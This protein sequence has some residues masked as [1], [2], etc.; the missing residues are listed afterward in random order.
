MKEHREIYINGQ[1][2][3]SRSPGLIEVINATSEAVIAR[4]PEGV[5]ED[6]DAVVGE[7][8]AAHHGVDMVSFTGST[9]AGRRV[10]ELAARTVKRV[11][12]ELGGKSAAI[13]LD[14]ADSAGS[15]SWSI[16]R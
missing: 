1:W 14:D 10:S 3:P 15:R 13:V 5:A 7:A 9:R 8:L 11:A 2:V 6:V 4:V 16:W 12:L